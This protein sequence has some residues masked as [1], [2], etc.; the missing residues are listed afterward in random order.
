MLCSFMYFRP[1]N[2][3]FYEKF[4]VTKNRLSKLSDRLIENGQNQLINRL[5]RRSFYPLIKTAADAKQNWSL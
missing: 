3:L 5:S 1:G 2:Q 4:I